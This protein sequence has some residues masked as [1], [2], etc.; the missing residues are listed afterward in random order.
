MKH[1]LLLLFPLFLIGGKCRAQ[2]SLRTLLIKDR[3]RQILKTN[4]LPILWG[5]VFFTSEYRLV[6]EAP[7]APWQSVMLGVSYL[8]KSPFANTLLA[9]ANGQKGMQLARN[10][11]I[12][13]FRV[14]GMYRFY[15]TH[16]WKSPQGV[17]I[18]PH[19]SYAYAKAT[20]QGNRTQ[21]VKLVYSNI[22][23][24]A[25]LQCVL[26]RCIA[27][28]GFAGLGYRSNYEELHGYRGSFTTTAIPGLFDG[29]KPGHLK[30]TLG[31][32]LGIAF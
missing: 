6:G 8:G 10:T 25:G 13:G 32:N 18:G 7:T 23:L 29:S 15:L 20:M 12:S 17:Y 9:G 21:Y 28:D 30:L 31:M 1:L 26:F 14:Q 3:Q 2:D 24:L 11:S 5:P 19:A 22:N 27:M 4:L 16:Y